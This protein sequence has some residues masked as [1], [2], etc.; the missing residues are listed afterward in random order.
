MDWPSRWTSVPF[1]A[2]V[3]LLALMVA[4]LVW[5][6]RPL[7]R[8]SWVL[9]VWLALYSVRL[10]SNVFEGYPG[11][12]YEMAFFCL[13]VAL[14][15]LA[16]LKCDLGGIERQARVLIIWLA[17]GIL[18]FAIAAEYLGWFGA[19]SQTF[20]AGRLSTVTINPITLG[21][22]SVSLLLATVAWRMQSDRGNSLVLLAL[23]SLGL[24]SMS[25]AG[26]RGPFVSLVATLTILVFA[27]PWSGREALVSRAITLATM[28]VA[29]LLI[30]YPLPMDHLITQSSLQRGL[31]DDVIQERRIGLEETKQDRVAL[32]DKASDER[33]ELLKSSS[34]TFLNNLVFGASNWVANEGH[35][36]HN[37]ILE[38]FQ[39]LGIV[40]GGIFLVLLLMSSY[41]AWGRIRHGE[42]MVPLL[43]FQALVGGQFSGSL[44]AYA[45]LWT[46]LTLLLASG[47]ITPRTVSS[48]RI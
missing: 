18:V 24:A 40:G 30:I 1:R 11:A 48:G 26:S 36:P 44:Y 13:A 20:I 45:Q 14:P 23:I 35:Y 43:F 38:A 29:C 41:R 28:G 31:S 25:Y 17:A 32:S 22:V 15:V 3:A 19:N 16:F 4:V 42:Y 8:W 6:S 5:R 46:T 21:H 39:N 10:S 27:A 37:L 7:N 2:V 47:A 9:V 12:I 34:T 33:L